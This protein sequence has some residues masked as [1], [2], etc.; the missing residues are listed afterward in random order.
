MFP[1]V[2]NELL[3]GVVTSGNKIS[4]ISGNSGFLGVTK[5]RD[6]SFELFSGILDLPP[7]GRELA[8]RRGRRPRA[9]HGSPVPACHKSRHRL[10]LHWCLVPIACLVLVQEARISV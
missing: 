1:D 4:L 9:R 7:L 10:Q 2:V 5:L 6:D 8:Q 3:S